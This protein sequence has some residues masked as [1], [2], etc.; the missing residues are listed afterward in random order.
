MLCSDDRN[1]TEKNLLRRKLCLIP[2]FFHAL[3]QLNSVQQKTQGR[4]GDLHPFFLTDGSRLRPGKGAFFQPFA[5]EAQPGAVEPD[6]LEQ[7][8]PFVDEKVESTTGHGLLHELSNDSLKA[9]H[10]VAHVDGFLEQVSDGV[11][12]QCKHRPLFSHAC[13]QWFWLSAYEDGKTPGGGHARL[14]GVS[15]CAWHIPFDR[16]QNCILYYGRQHDISGTQE[17]QTSHL[18]HRR[19]VSSLRGQLFCIAMIVFS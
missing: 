17:A 4:W 15:A 2:R 12:R 6:R 1:F 9:E 7:A 14:G 16:R 19:R 10:A 5:K 13:L 11:L 8:V 3:F 18:L